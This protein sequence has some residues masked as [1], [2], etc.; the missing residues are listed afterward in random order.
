MCITWYRLWKALDGY[1]SSTLIDLDTF[2]VFDVVDNEVVLSNQQNNELGIVVENSMASTIASSSNLTNRL[3][4][5]NQC[6][7]CT[8]F[9]QELKRQFNMQVR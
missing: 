1:S 3:K 2:Q 8:I 9:G 7:V 5:K 4:N 6:V